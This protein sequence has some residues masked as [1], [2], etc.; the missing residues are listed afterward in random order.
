FTTS[1]ELLSTLEKRYIS[2]LLI[3]NNANLVYSELDKLV[4][5]SDDFKEQKWELDAKEIVAL[6]TLK[7]RIFI[8]QGNEQEDRLLWEIDG[9]TGNI[10]KKVSFKPFETMEIINETTLISHKEIYFF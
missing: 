2:D 6:F 1:G 9:I 4:C 3:T 10:R 5:I 7:D 8:L